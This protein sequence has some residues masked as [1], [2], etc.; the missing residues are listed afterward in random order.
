MAT[1][2]AVPVAPG[3]PALPGAGT[4]NAGITLL[5]HDL[6]SL[7]G[8]VLGPQWG[9]FSFGL[10]VIVADSVVTLDYKQ[11]WTIADYPL[12]AGKFESYDKVNVPFNVNIRFA[13]GGSE[14]ERQLLLDSVAAVAKTL[15]LFDVV[16]PEAIYTNVN[17]N[18]YDYRRTA[19][20][21]LGMIVVDVWCQQV[22]VTA[23]A[24]FTNTQNPGAAATVSGGVV[25][26]EPPTPGQV[27][28][29]GGIGHA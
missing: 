8:E 19:A 4:F 12:E 20:S 27:G 21:G 18:H 26:A 28:K 10:P 29:I 7:F 22:Q 9:I 24:A 15:D 16:T 6:L 2:P 14:V 11:D 25:Q 17:I 5:V 23:R 1:F 13:A 3:V